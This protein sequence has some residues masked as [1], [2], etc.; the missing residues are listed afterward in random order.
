MK[1]EAPR[2]EA[3]RTLTTPT[4]T[5]ST[6]DCSDQPVLPGLDTVPARFRLDERTRRIGLAGVAAAKALLAEQAARRAE[7]ETERTTRKGGPLVTAQR[8][9]A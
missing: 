7:R 8:R 2:N 9:A 4:A 3:D 6:P 5:S 1:Q